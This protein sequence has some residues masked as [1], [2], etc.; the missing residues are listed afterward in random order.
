MSTSEAV[1]VELHDAIRAA[2]T[3]SELLQ[4]LVRQRVAIVE[5]TI[6]IDEADE[7]RLAVTRRRKLIATGRV[8]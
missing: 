4:V 7:L 2:R 6:T 3:P 8:R 5:R 1:L